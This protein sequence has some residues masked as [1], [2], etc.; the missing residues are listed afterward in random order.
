MNKNWIRIKTDKRL[1]HFNLFLN[2]KTM[3]SVIKTLLIVSFCLVSCNNEDLNSLKEQNDKLQK[4]MDEL[5]AAQETKEEKVATPEVG[6]LALK[7]EEAEKLLDQKEY[8]LANYQTI[9]LTLADLEKREVTFSELNLRYPSKHPKVITAKNA[10]DEYRSRFLREFDQVRNATA[11]KDYWDKNQ[12]EWNQQDLDQLSRL[13]IARRL[14]TA[15]ATALV[16]MIESQRKVYN[17]FNTQLAELN[18]KKGETAVEVAQGTKKE[19]EAFVVAIKAPRE[20]EAFITLSGKVR[21][22]GDAEIMFFGSDFAK[23]FETFRDNL[24]AETK[25]KQKS[26]LT[27]AMSDTRKELERLEN[28]MAS[29]AEATRESENKALQEKRDGISKKI[30]NLEEK[31]KESDPLVESLNKYFSSYTQLETSLV[32][33]A[34]V[35]R[36]KAHQLGM[37]LILKV[38][39]AIVSEGISRPKY[40]QNF[41]SP[42]FHKVYGEGPKPIVA[43]SLSQKFNRSSQQFGLAGI[44]SHLSHTTLQAGN[45]YRGFFVKNTTSKYGGQQILAVCSY[46]LSAS[47]NNSKI[48]SEMRKDLLLIYGYKEELTN[49]VDK[50]KKNNDTINNKFQVY[51]NS[52]GTS[53]DSIKERLLERESIERAIPSLNEELNKLKTGSEDSVKAINFKIQKA[54]LALKEEIKNVHTALVMGKEMLSVLSGPEFQ[55]ILSEPEKTTMQEEIKKFLASNKLRSVRTGSDGKFS[56]PQKARYASSFVIRKAWGREFFWL[57]KIGLEERSVI[58]SD[59]NISKVGR[60]GALLGALDYEFE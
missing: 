32:Q 36:D 44:S 40:P 11:D 14:L 8:A 1:L 45:D 21:P 7:L 57:I 42:T 37:D 56:V 33:A 22:L 58:L 15:R 53:K 47:L 43:L 18:T 16:I 35:T 6:I 28:S 51:A 48:A 41:Q 34:N 46:F 17:S 30:L 49:I 2:F 27:R 38:N 23:D 24:I 12:S 29:I 25:D 52:I 20:G 54:E 31:L 4:Q 26:R 3:K 19:K 10:L 13:Q 55:K 50:L 9:L 59:S 39:K 5:V 60:N